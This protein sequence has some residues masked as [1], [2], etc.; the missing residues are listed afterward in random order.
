MHFHLPKPLHG[1]REFVGEVAIIVLGVLIAL[2]A[3]QAVQSIE[4]RHKVKQAEV[5]LRADLKDDGSFATQYEILTPCANAYLDRMQR[6][7]L[8]HDSGDIARLYEFGPPF[9]AEP[10]KV[11]A[12]EN[13]TAGQVGDHMPTD[14]FQVYEEAFRGADLLRDFNLRDR[15]DYAA[16]MT[17]R[18]ALTA[19]TK[20]TA[21]ELAAIDRLRAYITVGRM[22]AKND[23]IRPSTRLGVSADPE[24]VD[25]YRQQESKCIALLAPARS[26]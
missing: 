5:R 1:W 17:G 7:L 10:W 14:R 18:F 25:Y 13:A 8:K 6:D 21:D 4:W 11:L 15:D 2:G 23:L 3:E 19:D 9:V 20:T 12:W 22:I 16:A 26:G 24:I